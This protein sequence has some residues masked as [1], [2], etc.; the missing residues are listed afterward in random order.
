MHNTN[1]I[2]QWFEDDIW[3]QGLVWDMD[4]K[5]ME[6]NPNDTEVV[7][8]ILVGETNSCLT[9]HQMCH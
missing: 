6:G 2:Q 1:D 8:S 9:Y 5:T 4:D 7:T 3:G